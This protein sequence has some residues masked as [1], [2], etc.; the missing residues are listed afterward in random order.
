M[1]DIFYKYYNDMLNAIKLITIKKNNKKTFLQDGF[2]KIKF[3]DLINFHNYYFSI[4]KINH[5]S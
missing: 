4:K 3:D 1:S 5:K 2:L